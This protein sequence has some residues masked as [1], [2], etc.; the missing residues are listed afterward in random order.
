MDSGIYFALAA[1][2][3]TGVFIGWTVAANRLRRQYISKLEESE[4][5]LGTAEGRIEGLQSTIELLRSQEQKAAEDLKELRSSLWAEQESRVKAETQLKK[6]LEQL[7]EERRL[8]EEAKSKLTETFKALAGDTLNNATE[9][10]LKL[11]KETLDK[12]LIEAKG[13]LVKRQ[14]AIEGMVKPLYER[15]SKFDEYLRSIEESRHRAY[16]ELNEQIKALSVAHQHLQRET[17]NLVNALRTPK[18]IGTWGQMTLRRVVELAGMSEHCDF[19]EEFSITTEDG[20]LRPD[21]IVHLPGGEVVVDA[22]ATFDAFREAMEADSED[23]RRDALSRHASQLRAH[24]MNLASKAYWAQF[25]EAPEFV[26]MFIPGESFFAA[27]VDIDKSL[28]E[29]ALEKRVIMATPTTLISL[30]HAVA[31]GWRQEQI[32]QN[33]RQIS[34]LGKELYGRMRTLAEHITEIGKGLEKANTAYNNAVGSLELR[35]LP[36]ARR[37]RDLGAGTGE[38]IPFTKPIPT[39]PRRITSPEVEED[40]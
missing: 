35:V 17:G 10:F 31:Y 38:D 7:E 28:L 29:D 25:D 3:A 32:A 13:D 9:G 22:K 33:A 14:E 6:A 37:F 18:V 2:L 1:C 8:L 39:T 5:R 36:S 15:L 12:A 40:E 34:E 16:G 23:E 11:A 4:R 21:L 30:L 24:M 20:R 27:A 26:V 19:T